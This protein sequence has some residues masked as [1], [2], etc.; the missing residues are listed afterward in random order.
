MTREEI[1][2]EKHKDLL[3]EQKKKKQKTLLKR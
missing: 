1:S 3:K 2:K